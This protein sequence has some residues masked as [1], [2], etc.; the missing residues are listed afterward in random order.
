MNPLPPM[1]KTASRPRGEL[2]S[3]GPLPRLSAKAQ[4]VELDRRVAW[5]H[6]GATGN[7][8]GTCARCHQETSAS[9]LRWRNDRTLFGRDVDGSWECRLCYPKAGRYDVKVGGGATRKFHSATA[10][11]P[12]ARPSDVV[13][14]A[15]RKVEAAGHNPVEVTIGRVWKVECVRLNEWTATSDNSELKFEGQLSDFILKL[16]K[17]EE[18]GKAIKAELQRT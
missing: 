7:V 10:F 15:Y 6:R 17:T 14:A 9:E 13:V 4:P 8:T 1:R 5:T 11:D 3:L 12:E 18:T 2:T 16:W